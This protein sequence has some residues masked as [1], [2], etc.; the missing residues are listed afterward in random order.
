MRTADDRQPVFHRRARLMQLRVFCQV[1]QNL[2]FTRAAENLGLAQPTVSLHVG[3]LEREFGASLFDRKD[4]GVALTPAGEHLYALVEPLVQ[5]IVNLPRSLIESIGDTTCN[6]ITLAA[7]A[8]GATFLLPPYVKRLRD[9]HPGIRVRVGTFGSREG[10]TRLVAEEVDFSLGVNIPSPYDDLQFRELFPY[11]MVVIAGMDHPL[12]CR[13]KIEPQELAAWPAVTRPEHH[14]MEEVDVTAPLMLNLNLT[15]KIEVSNLTTI[16]RFVETGLGIA[17]VPDFC[18]RDN[19][20]LSTISLDDRVPTGSYG[21]YT[22][23]G[24]YLSP[25]ALKLLRLIDPNISETPP[26]VSGEDCETSAPT[27]AS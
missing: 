27:L 6:Q 24:E 26:A 1:A 10:L 3:A 21:V 5:R 2:N 18:V 14:D 13:E 15:S 16:K 11:R 12:A 25:P 9:Q 23:R 7:T 8:T 19:D 20:R 17:V 4:V 22:R